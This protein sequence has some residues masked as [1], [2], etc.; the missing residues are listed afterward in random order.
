MN[1]QRPLQRVQLH[2]LSRK[3]IRAIPH[4]LR[5]LYFFGF[6]L[7]GKAGSGKSSAMAKLALDWTG[8]NDSADLDQQSHEQNNI[9]REKFDFVFTVPL[10]LLT[11]IFHW[12]KSSFNN[13]S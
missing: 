12:K 11:P 9:L 6:F 5:T 10:K 2:L 13:M 3:T 7:L 4:L 1:C 8:K